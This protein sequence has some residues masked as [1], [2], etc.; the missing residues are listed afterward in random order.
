MTVRDTAPGGVDHEGD[1]YVE[2]YD[3]TL[4]K[5]DA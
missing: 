1:D 2:L 3:E 4:G 5:G